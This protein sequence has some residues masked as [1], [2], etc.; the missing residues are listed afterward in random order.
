VARTRGLGTVCAGT[1]GRRDN[2]CAAPALVREG[3]RWAAVNRC[4]RGEPTRG[5][6][7]SASPP[8]LPARQGTVVEEVPTRQQLD[9]P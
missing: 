1:M 3:G 7:A 6:V 8:E 5:R 2:R 9:Q 4:Y